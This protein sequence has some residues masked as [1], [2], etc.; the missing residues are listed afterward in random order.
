[1]AFDTSAKVL[2]CPVYTNPYFGYTL[3][4]ATADLKVLPL[5]SHSRENTLDLFFR[6]V[7]EWL[8]Q[9]QGFMSVTEIVI[10][11]FIIFAFSL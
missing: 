1:M 9:T 2:R 10:R 5:S 4:S 6:L 3:K 8:G 11:V 7:P